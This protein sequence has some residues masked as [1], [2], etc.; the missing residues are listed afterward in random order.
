[1]KGVGSSLGNTR[2]KRMRKCVV[3]PV[4]AALL[5][6]HQSALAQSD[7]EVSSAEN[8]YAGLD[9][10]AALAAAAAAIAKGGLSHDLLVRATR[11]GAMAHAA[12][13][14]SDQAK[15]YFVQLLELEPD[16]QIDTKLGNI[17]LHAIDYCVPCSYVAQTPANTVWKARK[18]CL[19]TLAH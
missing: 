4:L 16:F 6:L 7:G 11:T 8:A 19:L 17:F 18:S 2:D 14:H 12:L 13:G 1:M 5:T 3:I 9:Y 10:S 15:D